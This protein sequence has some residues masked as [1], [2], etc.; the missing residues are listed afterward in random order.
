[1]L[2]EALCL[3]RTKDAIQLPGLL[4]HVR[5]L[6]FS[7]AER[8]Q[9]KNTEKILRRTIRHRV[10]EVEKSSK[11]GLFQVNLQLR[12]LCNNGTFQQPFSWNRRSY[13]AEREAVISALGQNTEITCSGCKLP[14]PILGSNRQSNG[15][16]ECTHVLCSECIEES[17]TLGDG[18]QMQPR[19][20]CLRWLTQARDEGRATGDEDVAKK[21]NEDDDD[22][23]FDTNGHSTKMR[24]LI[25]NVSKDLWTTK[26]YHT[27]LPAEK[28]LMI[29]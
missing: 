21:A 18:A 19:P 11:F 10:G 7:P 22:Y 5:M 28:K 15:F 3:R 6:E 14:M 1:M 2:L 16:R 9:Y 24:A 29:G 17:S 12:L 8:D 27:P 26:R 20:A 25:E 23:Y 13:Q 4:Q